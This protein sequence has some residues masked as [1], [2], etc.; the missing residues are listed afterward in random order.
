MITIFRRRVCTM[1]TGTVLLSLL[2]C[3]SNLMTR[4]VDVGEATDQA[5]V[6]AGD[7]PSNR[8]C[9]GTFFADWSEDT[10]SAIASAS[11]SGLVA[12]RVDG[13]KLEVL[14]D[15]HVEGAYD[16]V[17][18]TPSRD[19]TEISE[20][21]A[22]AIGI[23]GKDDKRLGAEAGLGRARA[24]EYAVVGQSVAHATPKT[25]SGECG[26]ATHYA[27]AISL[28]AYE[29]ASSKHSE[30]SAVVKLHEHEETKHHA[31]G[32]IDR[33][34]KHDASSDESCRTPLMLELGRIPK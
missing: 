34:S 6:R 33:C 14:P 8:K 17:A 27:R 21:N 18:V 28:G 31:E 11:K 22:I 23:V 26:R 19:R 29:L 5:T 4:N 7:D 9:D 15:C 1:A 3:G 16:W 12:V 20:E 13:C 2:G 30:V 32:D 25:A 24:I 10:A